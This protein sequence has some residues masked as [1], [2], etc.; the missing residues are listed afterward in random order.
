MMG[1]INTKISDNSILKL[2]NKFI[3]N[4]YIQIVFNI[5][6]AKFIDPRPHPL[7]SGRNT[8]E[9]KIKNFYFLFWELIGH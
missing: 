6:D 7:Y 5:I 2:K 8:F 1:C 9:N 3:K 4:I